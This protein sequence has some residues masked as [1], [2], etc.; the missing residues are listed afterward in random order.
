M[1]NFRLAAGVLAL[2]AGLPLAGCGGTVA[3]PAAPRP[4]RCPRSRGSRPAGGR[5]GS[6]VIVAAT[7]A[8]VWF[9]YRTI[10]EQ[11]VDSYELL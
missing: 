8:S 6:S 1:R 5:H 7:P 2:G 4:R 9:R 10:L 3:R 11:A